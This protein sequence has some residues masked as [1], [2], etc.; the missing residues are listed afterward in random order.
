MLRNG[1]ILDWS[2]LFPSADIAP[3]QRRGKFRRGT[4]Q[5]LMDANG[6][7]SISPQDYAVAMIDEVEKPRRVRQ[8]FSGFQS[9]ISRNSNRST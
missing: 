6:Q 2:F 7:T 9:G 5:M 4:D 3:D 8:R 1:P